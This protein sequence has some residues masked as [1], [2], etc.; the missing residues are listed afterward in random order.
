MNMIGGNHIT[1]SAVIP[2][3]DSTEN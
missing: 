3:R 1:W 2:C